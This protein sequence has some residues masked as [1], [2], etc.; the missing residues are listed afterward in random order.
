MDWDRVRIFLEV[1]RLG[2]IRT[3]A[4]RLGVNPSTVARQLTA[5]EEDL[6]TKLV[7]RRPSGCALTSEGYVLVTAAERAESE[8]LQV[9]DHLTIRRRLERS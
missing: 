9:C 1:A 8:F 5:L 7:E 6:K 3:A 2:Q 4:R